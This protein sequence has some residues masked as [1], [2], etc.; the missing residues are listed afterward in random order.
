MGEDGFELR[1]DCSNYSLLRNNEGNKLI[2]YEL[3]LPFTSAFEIKSLYEGIWINRIIKIIH[4]RGQGEEKETNA[5]SN[6]REGDEN[7]EP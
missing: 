5:S 6:G 4:H 7:G 3:Y 2:E 1:I